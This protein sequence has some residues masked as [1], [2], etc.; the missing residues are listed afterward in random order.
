M[1]WN[2]SERL[3]I[4]RKTNMLEHIRNIGNGCRVSSKYEVDSGIEAL[5]ESFDA[6]ELFTNIIGNPDDVI[7]TP[8]EAKDYTITIEF[9]KK[10][11]RIIAGSYDKKGLPEDF[12]E[13]AESVF[14][15]MRFYGFGEIL[16]PSVYG[17][18]KRRKTDYIY[19]GVTFDEGYKT[20]YY[21][22]DDDSIEVGDYV[23]VPAGSD[24]HNAVV[25]VVNVEYFAEENVPLPIEKTKRIIRKC[26]DADFDPPIIMAS[27]PLKDCTPEQLMQMHEDTNEHTL[28]L[29]YAKV[30]NQVGWLMHEL[31]SDNCA[32]ETEQRYQEWSALEEE[33]RSIIFEILEDENPEEFDKL[34]AEEKGY[35]NVV[36]P[37]MIRNNCKDVHGWWVEET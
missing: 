1:T 28:A 25:E 3:V 14:D 27:E 16:D 20:Y 2:Y 22:A 32:E 8:N 5:L 31:D 9:K 33:L 6:E 11:Q 35:Y 18:A 26:T 7:E 37:F 10:P 13:F 24:N 21:I 4:D 15:F 23:V 12:A 34:L 30:F 36:K 17:K 19:C 29:I